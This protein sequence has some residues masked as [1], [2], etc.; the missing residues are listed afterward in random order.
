MSIPEDK[1]YLEMVRTVKT[2]FLIGQIDEAG[3]KDLLAI[4][5]RYRT[6]E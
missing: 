6:A 5:H 3:M 4:L 1:E 2:W